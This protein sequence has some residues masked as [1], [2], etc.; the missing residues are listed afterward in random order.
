LA[1]FESDRL[2]DDSGCGG[3]VF[4]LCFEIFAKSS[5]KPAPP[6]FLGQPFLVAESIDILGQNFTTHL[7]FVIVLSPWC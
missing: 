5:D 7:K 2:A 3:Q 4:I 6:L 1:I